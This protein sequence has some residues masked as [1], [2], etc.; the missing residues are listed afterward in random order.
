M[1]L[2]FIFKH[3]NK[4]SYVIYY[5]TPL[6]HC[7]K[8][9]EAFFR[10]FGQ[11]LEALADDGPDVVVRQEIDHGFSFSSALYQSGLLEDLQLVGYRGLGHIQ[12]LCQIADTDLRLKK[13]E[14]DPDPGGIPEDLEEL[15]KIIELVFRGHLMKNIFYPVLMNFH[16]FADVY[17]ADRHVSRASQNLLINI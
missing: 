2:I 5:F 7:V 12:G 16:A 1:K 14:E 17:I 13:S 9:Q 8:R 4:C 3:M 6:C 11:V 10:L 15:R